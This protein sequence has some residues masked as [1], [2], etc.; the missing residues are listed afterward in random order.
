[1]ITQIRKYWLDEDKQSEMGSWS[2]STPDDEIWMELREQGHD[3]TGSIEVGEW[4][5]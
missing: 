3:G 5:E 1:M 2:V 4:T